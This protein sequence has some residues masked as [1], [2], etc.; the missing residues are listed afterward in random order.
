[1]LFNS[2][3]FIFLFLPLCLAGWFGLNHFRKYTLAQLFLLGMSLWFYGYFNP[4]YLVIII[5]SIVSNFLIT[6]I[7]SRTTSTA[8]RK[9]EVVLAVVWN[10]GVLFYYKYFDF[11]IENINLLA[12]TDYALRHI[13]LPLGISFFTFQQLSYVLDAYHQE[14]PRYTFLQYASYVAYFPQ[15]IAGPIVTHDELI[16]QFMDP[17][18]R[19]FDWDSFSKGLYMFILGLSKKVLIAD[20][21]GNAAN[22]GFG[23]IGSL[24]T[25]NAIFVSLAYTIQIYFDFSGYSDMAIG[26]GK[27]MNFD[28]PVNFDS[29]YKACTVT[30]FWQRWHM[31]LT[32]FFTKYIYIPLGG[33]RRGTARTYCN[34]LLVF[35]ISGLWHGASWAFVLWGLLH[36]IL[37]VVSRHFH[38]WFEKLPRALSWIMTFV[39]LDLTWILFRCENIPD[40]LH[41]FRQ[42]G[43]WRFG[44][45]CAELSSAFLLPEFEFVFSHIP[46]LRVFSLHPELFLLVLFGCAMAL[47]LIPQNA[48]WHMEQFHPTGWN[49]LGSIILIIWC[50]MSFSGV[51]T[52][53]Y[54]NF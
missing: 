9:A 7:L 17:S 42:L 50:I 3:I 20:T 21:F 11:F 28:L 22:W 16:P 29:P 10:L 1:M 36:G 41:F 51:S 14:V 4:S 49:L 53:L 31:T 45:I 12:H 54:F 43:T 6:R 18:K 15:L 48:R 52:F 38:S 35:L 40:A 13:L 33:N 47:L 19:R 25:L 46:F 39:F 23:N 26:L 5:V 30:E 37:N 34:I 27:M 2:Y 44:P 24:D 32:R 8:L